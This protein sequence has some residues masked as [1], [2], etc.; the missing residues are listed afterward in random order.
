MEV[1]EGQ[2]KGKV[3]VSKNRKNIIEAFT[4]NLNVHTDTHLHARTHTHTYNTHT[5]RH[6]A[7]Q[8]HTC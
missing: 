3:E 8:P 7:T 1:V 4:L 5:D 6:A 2:V